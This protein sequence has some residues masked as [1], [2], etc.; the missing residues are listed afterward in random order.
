MR[1]IFDCLRPVSFFRCPKFM[2]AWTIQSLRG[3]VTG[4]NKC[5]LIL[6]KKTQRL[7]LCTA[8]RPTLAPGQPSL[9]LV[10]LAASPLIKW[11]GRET[12][13]FTSFSTDVK[14]SMTFDEVPITQYVC[15][16]YGN[17]RTSYG[18]LVQIN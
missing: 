15:V 12:D 9:Q 16:A 10:S 18:F 6:H 13:N 14:N 8:C 1:V 4:W 3:F 5:S 7:L 2:S 17:I 11:P